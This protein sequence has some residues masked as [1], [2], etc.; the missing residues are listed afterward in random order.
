MPPVSSKSPRSRLSNGREP[1]AQLEPPA[2]ARSTVQRRVRRAM[3][4]PTASLPAPLRAMRPLQWTKNAVVAAA[5]IF[6]EKVIQLE[7]ALR[8]LGAVLVF[9]V[10]S[11]AIYLINDIRDAPADRLHP[12][13]RLRPIAAGELPVK[14][15]VWMATGLLV[16]GMTGAWLVRPEFAAVAAG[17]VALMIAYSGWLKQM[18]ILDVFAIAAGFVLRAVGGAVAIAVTISPWLLVCTA[19]LAL[20]VGFGKRRHELVTLHN[21]AGHRANLDSYSLPLLDQLLAVLGS[22]TVMAYS[23]YTFDASNVPRNH[24]MML[25]IPFVAYAVFRYLF[26][27][28]RR[29]LG[30]VPEQ[31][32]FTDRPLLVAILSWGI[33]SMAILA[34]TG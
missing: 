19:L 12:A 22:A 24:A 26:L 10:L 7:P 16:A 18:V 29:E 23:F 3:A 9:C 11:S 15:A 14:R 32:L 2:L 27:I 21:A 8:S 17:Y 30:G 6:D 4:S 33:A 31:L 25:T 28:H 34:L 1:V 20:F 13:K 5:L